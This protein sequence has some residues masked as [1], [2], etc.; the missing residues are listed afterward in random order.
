ML[1]RGE[2][3]QEYCETSGL[4]VDD[5]LKSMLAAGLDLNDIEYLE[6]LSDRRVLSEMG[7]GPAGLRHNDRDDVIAYMTA[8]ATLLESQLNHGVPTKAGD[9]EV[10]TVPQRL[11]GAA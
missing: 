8:W 3:S 7:V 1:V 9:A 5:I 2:V 6:N 4:K 10:I 11:I